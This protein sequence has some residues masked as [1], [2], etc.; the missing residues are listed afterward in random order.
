MPPLPT[1]LP[2][3]CLNKPSGLDL[4]GSGTR[5][6]TA[7]QR[8]PVK[9]DFLLCP[10][11]VFLLVFFLSLR[12]AH[13]AP[14][15]IDEL[16]RHSL[17]H[18]LSRSLVYLQSR[19]KET[20]FP[21]AHTTI[22]VTRLIDTARHLRHLAASELDTASFQRHLVDDF[23]FLSS[24]SSSEKRL[25]VTGYY[26]PV[27]LGSLQRKPP[28]VHP[29]YRIPDDLVVRKEAE[30]ATVGRLQGGRLHPYWTRG[31]I[32]QGKLLQG[33]ELVWLRDPFDVFTLH[34]Q[35]SG[36]LRLPDGSLRGVH[37]GQGNG[38][39][40]TSIGRFLVQTGRM[41]LSDVT[42]ESLR[43]YL[44]DHPEE[45]ELILHQNDSYIFFAWCPPGPAVGSLNQPLTPG[46]SAAA[47][48]RSYPPGS[49]L[50]VKSRRPVVTG[51][52][53]IQWRSMR[54]L[55]TVQDTGSAIKGPGRLDVFWGTGEQAGLEAGQMKE[56]GE[57]ALLLLKD[58]VIP[59]SGR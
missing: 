25:L 23:D 6:E 33:Q 51:G 1:I 36:I 26:Q 59:R 41:Q 30:T 13:A 18:A 12:F 49:V 53:D 10:L 37:Y 57:V 31:E 34:V 5:R 54:R 3:P 58:A 16:D 48:Q 7:A 45:L 39:P 19:P 17:V 14:Q 43:V 35:G 24:F 15:P 28:F 21:F 27:F 56:S 29:L 44:Q 9:G 20:R 11:I 42:M 2:S 32:E 38:H 40:Y 52:A 46:R 22:P 4:L 47:D 55:L 50:W 8:S